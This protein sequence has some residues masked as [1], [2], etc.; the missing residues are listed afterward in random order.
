MTKI[1]VTRV[2]ADRPGTMLLVRFGVVMGIGLLTQAGW[3]VL[4]IGH[5]AQKAEC[6]AA[7]RV[8][9]PEVLSGCDALDE[10]SR[11]AEANSVAPRAGF[12]PATNR[13]TAGCSTT[14]LP[15]NT[16]RSGLPHGQGRAYIRAS[17][18]A[19][20]EM[21]AWRVIDGIYPDWGLQNP[22]SADARRPHGAGWSTAGWRRLL[23]VASPWA[24]DGA[25]RVGC[26]V[27]RFAAGA[28][29]PAAQRSED[30]S[31]V[32]R[33]AVAARGGCRRTGCDPPLTQ[34]KR[35]RKE[36]GPKFG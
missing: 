14:E 7:L 23:V 8:H 32:A 26:S 11:E 25:S 15:G 10:A 12:E 29:V 17:L 3:L 19:K 34:R 20:A 13:L 2:P 27:G 4:D 30:H 5:P 6:I 22:R 28:T 16:C 36:P 24:V 18:P 35:A 31:L 33:P 21:H 1:V 9:Y